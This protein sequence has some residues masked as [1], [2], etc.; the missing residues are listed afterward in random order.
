[1]SPSFAPGVMVG[2]E[3]PT[4]TAALSNTISI[5]DTCGEW[6]TV[7]EKLVEELS[8]F[9]EIARLD[10]SL[11]AML[12][13]VLVTYYDLR[14]A[15][16][17]LHQ[18]AGRVEAFPPARHDCR[19]V[20]INMATA[21]KA[22]IHQFGDIMNFSMLRD[23]ALIEFYDMRAAQALLALGAGIATP[24][25]HE[26][27]QQPSATS[28]S[29]AARLLG[30][31]GE[32]QLPEV[33]SDAKM[34]I[35]QAA[36]GINDGSSAHSSAQSP[37]RGQE[38]CGGH[39]VE[40][41]KVGHKAKGPV[42]TKVTA[43]EFSKFDINAEK[44]R[45]GEDP[46]TTVMVRNLG[47]PT[48]RRDFLEFLEKCGLQKRYSFFYMPC[49]DRKNVPAGFAFVNFTSPRDVNKLQEMLNQGKWTE[50]I[51]DTTAKTPAMSYARFQGH[52]ELMRHFTA[53]AA[54]H[55]L[56]PERRPT[57]Q[58]LP[59]RTHV[60]GGERSA[61]G[62]VRHTSMPEMPQARSGGREEQGGKLDSDEVNLH[63]AL[64]EGAQNIA[65]ILMW[66][67]A[68]GASKMVA[69][70]TMAPDCIPMPRLMHGARQQGGTRC[71]AFLPQSGNGRDDCLASLSLGM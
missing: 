25:P 30:L 56:D 37:T 45:R 1:M 7:Q 57:F 9:G 11:A 48:S 23:D 32:A 51:G 8:K 20:R 16:K 27:F 22:G 19:V 24:W 12:N 10:A 4:G 61:D 47:R 31:G 6:L 64:D 67:T 29:V 46:R 54:L 41:F 52:D 62:A 26:L 21:Q 55:D 42:R 50:F 68:A 65:A 60:G 28:G 43:M 35:M 5:T 39:F 15:Q 33:V 49:K 40:N 53:S 71:R 3:S 59:Q 44:I 18:L 63:V 14:S 2:F 34:P 58:E 70:N 17:A 13:R 69:Q 36:Q 38:G 66:G